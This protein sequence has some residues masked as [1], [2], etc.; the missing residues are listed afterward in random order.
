MPRWT[1]I[2]V[3]AASIAGSAADYL[4]TILLVEYFH[5]WYLLANFL[6]NLVGGGFL[7]ILSRKWIFRSS[8]GG[9]RIQMAKFVLMFAGNLLLSAFGVFVVTHFF[10][11]NYIVSKTII[12]IL[13]GVSYNYIMQRKFVFT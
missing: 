3:Q 2:K 4:T 10:R 5:C 7:F 11:V 1:F 9:V 12:S 6:G 13:L 8:K